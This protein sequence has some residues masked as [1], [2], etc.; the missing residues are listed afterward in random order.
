MWAV[1][2]KAGR[3]DSAGRAARR[4]RRRWWVSVSAGDGGKASRGDSA[5]RAAREWRVGGSLNEGPNASQT[6]STTNSI[7][8][9]RLARTADRKQ[10]AGLSAS[11][12]VVTADAEVAASQTKR[13]VRA[14]DRRR[15]EGPP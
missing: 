7:T 11:G 8:A 6:K 15:V 12:W 4:R 14:A 9:G 3:G 1:G 5:G 13:S 2:G 10:V